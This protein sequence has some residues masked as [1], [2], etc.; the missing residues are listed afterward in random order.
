MIV[1]GATMAVVGV[2]LLVM[3]RSRI[4][5]FE[6]SRIQLDA[7]TVGVGPDGVGVSLSGRF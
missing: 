1:S 7:P 5:R 2:P 3:G 4:D 6:R